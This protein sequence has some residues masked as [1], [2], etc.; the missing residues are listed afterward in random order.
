MDSG[1]HKMLTEVLRKKHGRFDSALHAF[2]GQ[3]GSEALAL[4][5]VMSL[6]FGDE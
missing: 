2:N 3:L 5:K 4:L 1:F 6:H